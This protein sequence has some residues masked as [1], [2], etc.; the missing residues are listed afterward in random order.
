MDNLNKIYFLTVISNVF[1]V[2]FSI[3]LTSVQ[4]YWCQYEIYCALTFTRPCFFSTAIIILLLTQI[5]AK[6]KL[7]FL[8]HIL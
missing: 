5:K 3:D 2:L 4:L 6:I 1:I 8:Y 7:S